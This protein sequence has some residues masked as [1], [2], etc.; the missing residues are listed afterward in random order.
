MKYHSFFDSSEAYFSSSSTLD[1]SGL[2][3]M[4]RVILVLGHRCLILPR[5]VR[6][7]Q[8]NLANFAYNE[9]YNIISDALQ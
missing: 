8:V 2:W 7:Q 3:I 6:R 5:T 4:C 1:Q 9:A